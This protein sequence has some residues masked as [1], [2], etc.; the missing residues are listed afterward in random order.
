[1][2]KIDLILARHGETSANAQGIMQGSLVNLPLNDLGRRQASA[3]AEGMKDRNVDWIVTSKL[4]R[5]IETARYVAKYHS[6]APLTCDERLNEISWGEADGKDIKTVD[7][8]VKPVTQG[9]V[10]GDFDAKILGGESANECKERILAAFGDILNEARKNK[11]KDVVVCIHGRIM[12]V[13]MAV[14][15]DKDLR[16][17]ERFTHANCCYHHIQVEVDDDEQI[18]PDP[19]TLKFEVVRIDVRDHLMTLQKPRI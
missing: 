15:V 2:V 5:A 1:M 17:M 4:D 13:I 10:S 16:T 3:L 8:I 6:S 14:L 19:W 18:M 12:R 7:P 9:W 11:H